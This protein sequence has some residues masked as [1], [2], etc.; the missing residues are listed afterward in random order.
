MSA[1]SSL[2]IAFLALFFVG[3][4]SSSSA[5]KDDSS[6]TQ[7]MESTAEETTEES[8]AAEDEAAAESKEGSMELAVCTGGNVPEGA[9]NCLLDLGTGNDTHWSDS[10]G[11]D[12]GTA[13]CH[14]E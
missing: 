9:T 8:E 4:S 2:F 7:E 13:G 3:C 1:R 11:V 14:Y 12:T 10:D 6:A 5:D